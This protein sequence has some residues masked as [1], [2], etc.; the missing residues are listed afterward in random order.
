MTRLES[1]IIQI[2][3]H[4]GCQPTLQGVP[5]GDVVMFFAKLYGRY[6]DG[7]ICDGEYCVVYGPETCLPLEHP[8]SELWDAKIA[9]GKAGLPLT[10][11]EVRHGHKYQRGGGFVEFGNQSISHLNQIFFRIPI[12][13]EAQK[14][15]FNG[16]RIKEVYST[17]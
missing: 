3:E 1:E 5:E 10:I 7:K 2:E 12:P 11:R 15:S 4:D 9:L 16:E 8:I 13:N 17:L 6:E 14:S